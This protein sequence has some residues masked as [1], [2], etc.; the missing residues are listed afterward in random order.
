MPENQKTMTSNTPRKIL[1]ANAKEIYDKSQHLL[2]LKDIYLVL[3]S[4]GLKTHGIINFKEALRCLAC[5]TSL[6]REDVL[7]DINASLNSFFRAEK[8]QAFLNRFPSGGVIH[9]SGNFHLNN[10]EF[11]K[12]PVYGLFA[13]IEDEVCDRLSLSLNETTRTYH[14]ILSFGL[15]AVV[16]IN[17]QNTIEKKVSGMEAMCHNLKYLAS[18]QSWKDNFAQTISHFIEY[19]KHNGQIISLTSFLKAALEK[20]LDTSFLNKS[21]E[22]LLKKLASIH[23]SIF[24]LLAHNYTQTS[25]FHPI[26]KKPPTKTNNEHL[27][28]ILVKPDINPTS[29]DDL[30]SQSNLFLKTIGTHR[31]ERDAQNLLYSNDTLLPHEI[32]AVEESIYDQNNAEP[33]TLTIQLCRALALY[34]GVSMKRIPSILIGSPELDFAKDQMSNRIIIDIDNDTIFLPTPIQKLH[35]ESSEQF[36]HQH[37]PLILESR[38]KQLLQLIYDGKYGVSLKE[39]V[40]SEI[41]EQASSFKSLQE[42]RQHR[43]T[44]GKVASVL[45]KHVF[46]ESQ[47]EVK[48]AYLQGGSYKFIHMGCYYTSLSIEKLNSLYIKVCFKVFKGWSYNKR[49]LPVGQIGSQ[50]TPQDS[51]VRLFLQ[52]KRKKLETLSL[53]LKSHDD[54]WKFHN[55]LA[56]YT[57]TLLNLSTTH[58]PHLD[59]YY[60]IHNFLEDKFVQITEKVVMTGFEGRV[61]AL[62]DNAI[63]QINLYLKHLSNIQKTLSSQRISKTSLL[64]EKLLDGKVNPKSGTPLFFLVQNSLITPITKS[65]LKK[66]YLSEAGFE[67]KENFNRHI[68]STFMANEN[69]DRFLIAN[70]M[71]HITKGLEP[72]SISSNLSPIN[73]YQ[74]LAPKLNLLCSVLDA[75]ATKIPH[76]AKYQSIKLEDLSWQTRALGPFAREVSRNTKLKQDLV[77]KIDDL[78]LIP[79]DRQNNRF[80]INSSLQNEH[81]RRMKEIGFRSPQKTL[82]AYYKHKKTFSGWRIEKSSQMNKSPFNKTFGFKYQLGYRY[83]QEIY[84]YILHLTSCEQLL[85]QKSAKSMLALSALASGSITTKKHLIEIANSPRKDYKDIGISVA[86][87]LKESEKK[88]SKT[89]ILNSISL[90]LLNRV[91]DSKTTLTESDINKCLKKLALPKLHKLTAYLQAYQQIHLPSISS[92]FVNTPP[93][94]NSIGCD[95][96]RTM[97]GDFSKPREENSVDQNS[98][99]HSTGL[100]LN[101]SQNQIIESRLIQRRMKKLSSVLS[102]NDRNKLNYKNTLKAVESFEFNNTKPALALIESLLIYWIKHELKKQHLDL[103]SIATYFSK[104]YPYL[105]QGFHQF[106]AMVEIDDQDLIEVVYPSVLNLIKKDY[107]QKKSDWPTSALASFHQF[108]AEKF[109]FTALHFSK[110]QIQPEPSIQQIISEPEYQACLQAL[111]NTP[112]TDELTRTSLA[113]SLIFIKRLGLRPNELFKLQR[114]NV[115]LQSKTVHITGNHIQGEKSSRGNRLIPYSIFFTPYEQAL[116]EEWIYQTQ[117]IQPNDFLLFNG[118]IKQN[119]YEAV[120]YRVS[121]FITAL[122]RSVTGNHALSIKSFR[123][124]FASEAFVNLFAS[125]VPNIIQP[126]KALKQQDFTQH[127]KNSFNTKSPHNLSWLLADWLGHSTPATSFQYYALVKE[128]FVYLET[129]RHLEKQYSYNSILKNVAPNNH[130][131]DSIFKNLN[132]YKNFKFA[133]FYQSKV[134]QLE[135]MP[136]VENQAEYLDLFSQ[137]LDLDRLQKVLAAFASGENDHTIDQLLGLLPGTSASVINVTQNLLSGEDKNQLPDTLLKRAINSFKWITYENGEFRSGQKSTITT[138][139][140][141][142]SLKISD[143]DLK[144]LLVLWKKQLADSFDT[145]NTFII[146]SRPELESFLQIYKT[147]QLHD[148]YGGYLLITIMGIKNSS[149]KTSLDLFNYSFV[150]WEDERQLTDDRFAEVYYGLKLSTRNRDA[151]KIRFCPRG[152]NAIAFWANLWASQI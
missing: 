56:L 59:P 18:N 84:R 23:E 1:Q 75:A 45:S 122:V 112:N 144:T 77:L 104:I 118:M 96:Y 106:M 128:L 149:V 54:L 57:I 51:T 97:F 27:T 9:Q 108:L 103:S 147:L 5:V 32:A 87:D 94:F 126:T 102:K 134:S 117:I 47:D 98:Q 2:D 145:P 146:H 140:I 136:F 88:F 33:N 65:T 29:D 24:E 20:K 150:E 26:P 99:N 15:L 4:I 8:K 151:K 137:R 22:A 130:N 116:L 21:Q 107:T 17:K 58:R 127:I 12:N 120:I 42:F 142:N 78:L 48:V 135:S 72:Y 71:G 31:T 19:R 37:L 41:I 82:L 67:L 69:I 30:E 73:L 34:Y 138:N 95:G 28:E 7:L 6:A 64:I 100:E 3:R 35:Q 114:K 132:R 43:I 53:S 13:G 14:P 66:Y 61:S 11:S 68:F 124:S 125:L 123:K 83:Y 101:C 85:D 133:V 119:S 113:L 74:K 40:G 49:K 46:H 105:V 79:T 90:A 70:Q 39:L 121:K 36:N 148:A 129:E 111:Q 50:R 25:D 80:Y 62:S 86:I 16:L 81:L 76:Y 131:S 63:N 44:S 110:T 109:D 139:T 52:K 115:C 93:M 89:W 92:K 141:S 38:I 60:S 55:E 152:L 10:E 91:S 143:K